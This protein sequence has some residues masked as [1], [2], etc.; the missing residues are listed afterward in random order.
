MSSIAG[1]NSKS[2]QHP[3]TARTVKRA[4]APQPVGELLTTR[5]AVMVVLLGAAVVWAFWT[6]FYRQHLLSSDGQDWSH[7]Y[8]VPLISAYLIWQNRREIAATQPVVF[9]PGLIPLVMSVP[10]YLLFQLGSLSTH[11]GQ[12]WSMILAVFGLCLLLTGPRMIQ[13]LFLPICYLAFG[14]TVAEMV[15]IKITYLLQ[16]IAAQGGYNLLNLLG[17]QTDINGNELIIRA[18]DGTLLPLNI[19]E[20]CSGMRMVIAF[21]ALSVVVALVALRHWWQRIGLMLMGLPVAVAMNIIRVAVLGIAS[22]YNPHL[23]K[24]EAHM[25]IGFAL[26]VVAF[27]VFMGLASLLKM[28]VHDDP[29]KQGPAP[30]AFKPGPLHVS[31]L[32]R[33][34]F[35]T[36]LSLLLATALGLTA[37]L[38]SLNIYLHKKEIHAPGNRNVATLPTETDN[39]IMVGA[40]NATLSVEMVEELGTSNYL[41]RVYEQKKAEPGKPKA[42]VQL[43]LAYYTGM[44]DTVPHVPE[45]CMTA[46]GNIPVTLSEELPVVLDRTTWRPD[47]LPPEGW[48]GTPVTTGRTGRYSDKPNVR[49]RLPR[50]IEDLKMRFSTFADRENQKT[51]AGYFFMANGGLTPSPEGVR[52]LAF[53]LQDDYAYY[54][55]VQTTVGGQLDSKEA[56]RLSGL[57]LSDLMPEIARCAPDWVEVESGNYPSDNP[58]KNKTK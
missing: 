15:M 7:A 42:M 40:S 25:F 44:I 19:A 14:V 48:E 20:A 51:I 11:M 17:V 35:V 52:L 22:L 32:L 8:M 34:A 23:A 46:H 13:L 55:K 18:K 29:V 27:F 45:R 16:N 53:K 12:G 54:L 4:A 37:V 33:P 57:L 58:R 6:F 47:G 31:G 26:L 39:W 1:T 41:M 2:G 43:H 56:A 49:V 30:R 10:C 3:A 38:S 5:S 36:A 50:G 9:W 28:T 21:A 24:G